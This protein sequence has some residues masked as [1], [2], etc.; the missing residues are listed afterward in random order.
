MTQLATFEIERSRALEEAEKLAELN[1]CTHSTSA[2]MPLLVPQAHLAGH[3]NTKQ[4][5]K[6]V[7]R[8][9]EEMAALK[10]EVVTLRAQVCVVSLF[11]GRLLTFRQLAKVCK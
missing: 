6:Y 8:M 7:E 11:G 1:V 3:Q 9:R 2:L 5:I 4:K 10:K